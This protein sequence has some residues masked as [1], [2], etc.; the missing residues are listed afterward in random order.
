LKLNVLVRK[1]EAYHVDSLDLYAARARAHYI[2]QAAK[3][4]ACREDIIKLDLGRVLLKLEALQAERIK[5]ALQVQPEVPKMSE[6]EAAEAL[7]LLRSPD[8]LTRIVCDLAACGLI[9][10]E[11][12]KLAGYLAATSRKLD[13]PLAI[14]VQSS[15]AAGKSSL[16][17]AVL[18]FV[19]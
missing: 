15:T 4:L 5:A 2:G 19:P 18:A 3:E 9:G 11:T 17:D 8:L 16:M 10:E 12:N 13:A 14:L 1:A 7:A 6:T